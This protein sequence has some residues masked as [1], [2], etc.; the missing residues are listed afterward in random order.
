MF[1]FKPRLHNASCWLDSGQLLYLC[2]CMKV[3]SPGHTSASCWRDR[4]RLF[5]HG[6]TYICSFS[7]VHVATVSSVPIIDKYNISMW[8]QNTRFIVQKYIITKYIVTKILC[9]EVLQTV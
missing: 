9:A 5:L 8:L 7:L 4:I 3:A 6:C 2:T 1:R